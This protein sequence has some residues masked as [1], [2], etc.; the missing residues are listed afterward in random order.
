MNITDVDDK[1]IFRARRNHLLGEFMNAAE[2]PNEV[3]IYPIQTLNTSSDDRSGLY[4][5]LLYMI[6][7]S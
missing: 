3:C 4:F 6:K 2:D 7:Q 1:I 5:H